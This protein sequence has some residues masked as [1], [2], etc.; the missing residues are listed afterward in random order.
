MLGTGASL[1]SGELGVTLTE[2][3]IA[4]GSEISNIPLSPEVQSRLLSC[5]DLEQDGYDS[6]ASVDP[7]ADVADEGPFKVDE[8]PLQE[9]G[10][11]DIPLGVVQEDTE[12]SHFIDIPQENWRK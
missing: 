12:S 9:V 8:P 11:G 7:Y 6:D 3:H 5:S 4:T 2:E 10:N 1:N